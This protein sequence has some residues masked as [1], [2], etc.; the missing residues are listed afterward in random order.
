M[1]NHRT[2]RRKYHHNCFATNKSSTCNSEYR[3][4]T[5]RLPG[6]ACIY[7]HRSPIE[8]III[9]IGSNIDPEKNLCRAAELLRKQWPEI[10]FSN[11]YTTS[12]QEILDQPE[13]LNAAARITSTETCSEVLTQLQVIE[14]LLSKDP[15]YR[16]GPRTIDLDILLA[17]DTV[18]STPELTVPH[19]KFA[20]RR[21]ALAPLYELIEPTTLHP[22]MKKSFADLLEATI[23][24]KCTKI[25]LRL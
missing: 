20:V 21:F 15:P 1:Q 5:K 25:A 9:G 10:T 17:G 2:T 11:V 18:I 24:Q 16:F 4:T 22:V 7:Y 8:T 13:F 12:P 14:Q 6:S 19:P 3:K 23:D